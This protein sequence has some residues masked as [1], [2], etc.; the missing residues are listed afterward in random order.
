[1]EMHQVRY[2]VALAKHLNFTRAADALKVTQPSLTR[3]IQ[4]L[5]TELGGSLFRRERSNTHLTELG[6]LM[7]R[8]LRSVLASAETANEQAGRLRKGLGATLW[9]G[10]CADV[11][12]ELPASLIIDC[13]LGSSSL[14]FKVETGTTDVIQRRLASGDFDAAFLSSPGGSHDCLDLRKIHRDSFVVAFAENHRFATSQRV[15][16][17]VSDDV[18]WVAE[19]VRTGLGCAVLP[20]A[21]ARAF[22]LPH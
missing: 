20:R 5:E 10:V 6:R 16:R 9:I 14:A 22:A 12:P 13:S 8:H 21:L 3:A 18:R 15:V 19:F 1:M 17:H 7:L 2:F 11:E 4:K